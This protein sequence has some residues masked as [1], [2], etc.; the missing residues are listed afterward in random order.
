MNL[1]I[2]PSVHV[3][4][5]FEFDET[6]DE[7]KKLIGAGGTEQSVPPTPIFHATAL[8]LVE[9]AKRVT[10]CSC[11]RNCFE[12]CRWFLK[13]LIRQCELRVLP[14]VCQECRDHLRRKAFHDNAL[15][16]YGLKTGRVIPRGHKLEYRWI[17]PPGVV[18]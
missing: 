2:V 10:S 18:C 9:R 4:N 16:F 15:K 12:N 7:G 1:S 14:P 5:H 17:F 8:C 11:S 3:R 6:V 13:D